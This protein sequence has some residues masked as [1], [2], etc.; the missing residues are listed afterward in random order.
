MRQRTLYHGLAVLAAL[1]APTLLS[2]CGGGN[3]TYNPT[4][5]G[6]SSAPAV[7]GIALTPTTATL[8]PGGTQTFS[9]RVTG[10]TNTAVTWSVPGGDAN[11][12]I[13]STGVYTAPATPGTYRVIAA[14]VADP[15]KRATATVTV[16]AAGPGGL[17]GTIQ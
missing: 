7:V 17:V 1:L 6:D 4:L 12:T 3:D 16:T 9:A 14:S 8:P 13:T 11:G 5:A 15:S 2:G 10:T